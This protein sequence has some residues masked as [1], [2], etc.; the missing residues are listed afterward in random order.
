MPRP[1]S[2]PF[3]AFDFRGLNSASLATVRL[4]KALAFLS[5]TDFGLWFGDGLSGS[6]LYLVLQTRELCWSIERSRLKAAYPRVAVVG[7]ALL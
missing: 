1:T 4:V 5:Y 3:S 7:C 2:W 6:N